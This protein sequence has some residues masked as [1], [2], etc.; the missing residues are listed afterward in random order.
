MIPVSKATLATIRRFP[1]L[2]KR[3]SM[4]VLQSEV[5]DKSGI[6]ID[7]MLMATLLYFAENDREEEIPGF[8]DFVQKTVDTSA[9]Y[10]EDAVAEGLRNRLH[11]LGIEYKR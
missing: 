9:E 7:T 11:N 6:A 1:E 4:Q 2:Y 3:Q 8:I 10:Y 5:R